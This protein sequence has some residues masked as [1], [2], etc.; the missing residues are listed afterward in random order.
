MR[1]VLLTFDFDAMSVWIGTYG[2]QTPGPISRGEFGVV[3]VRRILET[4]GRHGVPATFFVP[5]HTA[6]AFP[7]A[8]RA[9]D[10]A[11]HEI[12]HHGFVHERISTLSPAEERHVLE[13]G[14]GILHDVTGKRPVGY[15]SPSGDFTSVTTQLLAELGFEYDSSLMGSDFAP[16]WVRSGD[17]FAP[18]EPYVF[19]Q[20]TE[21]VE[22][23]WSWLLDDWPNFEYVRGGVG[24]QSIKR[25]SDVFD[26]WMGEFEYFTKNVDDGCFTLI[27]HPQVIGRGSRIMMLDR[28]IGE[29]AKH[30]VVFCTA[31]DASLAARSSLAPPRGPRTEF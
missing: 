10:A 24:P 21:I 23:P 13:R 9:I 4:L 14:T 22:L 1:R 27:M 29:M 16:Y 20:E 11:G 3:G 31:H 17:R 6:L 25:P 7:H 15:R 18:D 12:G 8:V 5:G 2:E 19:G 26:L 28:L 30:D